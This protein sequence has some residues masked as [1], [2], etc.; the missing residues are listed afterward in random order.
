MKLTGAA[1]LVSRG[2]TFLQAAPAAYPYRSAARSIEAL[3][4]DMPLPR[5]HMDFNGY[6]LASTYTQEDIRRQG[7]TLYPGM[8]C[9]FYD[10][11]AEA[12]VRGLL[13][14]AGEIWWDEE[15]R[16]F[17]LDM[18]TVSFQLTPG[19]DVSVLDSLYPE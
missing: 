17:M 11:D 16:R 15:S 9:V 4:R 2:T 19:S 3:R 5:I 8:R 10:F 1:I 13:H 18:R 6:S 7:L 12:G 14:T